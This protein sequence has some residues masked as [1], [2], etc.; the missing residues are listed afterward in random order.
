MES[1]ACSWHSLEFTAA[2][3]CEESVCGWVRQPGNTVSN[4]GFL[5][6]GWLISHHVRRYGHANLVLLAYSGS[7]GVDL[8][9]LSRLV[10]TA[11]DHSRLFQHLPRVGLHVCY[12]HTSAH[13]VE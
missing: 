10:N 13:A 2:A 7:D 12:E 1:L 6:V 3:F 9:V 5:L 4:V 8:G 11:G